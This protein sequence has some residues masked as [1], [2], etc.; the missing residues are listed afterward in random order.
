MGASNHSSFVINNTENT[1]I[2]EI[3]GRLWNCAFFSRRYQIGTHP[4]HRKPSSGTNISFRCGKSFVSYAC[5]GCMLLPNCNVYLGLK[6]MN[7]RSEYLSGMTPWKQD[8]LKI[9]Q[10]NILKK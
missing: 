2:V 9:L 4:M 10:W 8:I 7:M 1:K 6:Y 3:Y 5:Q